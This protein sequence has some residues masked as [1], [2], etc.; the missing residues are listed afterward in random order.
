MIPRVWFFEKTKDKI[1]NERETT[2]DT[3]ETQ[4]ILRDYNKLCQ[5][6]GQ[7]RI[8][9]FLEI[10]SLLKLKQEKLEDLNR[11]IPSNEN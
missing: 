5:Q 9:N 11:L 7:A 10:Y 4:K 3:K 2:T 1:R 8:G 6:T